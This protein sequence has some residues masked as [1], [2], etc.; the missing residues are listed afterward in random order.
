MQKDDCF[1]L[2]KVVRPYG[3]K[4]NL[5]ILL[6]VDSPED[7]KELE[8]VFLATTGSQELIPFFIDQI[9]ILHK[10]QARIKFDS[11]NTEE[12]AKRLSKSE[13]YLPLDFLPEL[14]GTK[15]YYHEIIGFD[16]IDSEKGN[17]GTVTSIM[18][19]SQELLEIK[20]PTNKEILIPITDAIL[21][22][23]DRKNKTIS[24]SAPKGLIEMYL[25]D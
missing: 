11:V 3:Y 12:E 17:I 4:G 14:T 10:G 23:I 20:H 8:S 7:Y 9:Q 22:S 2:G 6:D 15:F 24:I 21:K 13:L 25:E 19:A 1:Y 18:E 16:V 5:A